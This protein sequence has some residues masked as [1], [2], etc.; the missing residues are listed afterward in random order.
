M[1][2][3]KIVGIAN[4]ITVII[5]LLAATGDADALNTLLG[6]AL[7]ITYPLSIYLPLTHNCES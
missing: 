6:F 1:D 7:I 4:T 5:F 2:K 3:I